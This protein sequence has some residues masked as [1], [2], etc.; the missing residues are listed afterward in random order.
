MISWIKLRSKCGYMINVT[1]YYPYICQINI[2]KYYTNIYSNIF[3][4][5]YQYP[6]LIYLI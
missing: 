1:I 6:Y 3:K 4:I 2:L 5:Q